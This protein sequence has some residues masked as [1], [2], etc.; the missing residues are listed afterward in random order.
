MDPEKRAGIASSHGTRK[1]LMTFGI[2]L[3]LGSGKTH[4]GVNH[5]VDRS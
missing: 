5:T 4:Q 1:F 2:V 3:I